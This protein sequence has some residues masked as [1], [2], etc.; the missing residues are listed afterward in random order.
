S[1]T[2]SP[3]LVVAP[4]SGGGQTREVQVSILCN[5][6]S[7]I[8][9]GLQIQAPAGWTVQPARTQF[10]LSRK[11]ESYAAR[12]VLH[13]P[14]GTREGIYPLEAAA[15]TGTKEFR[16]GYRIVSYPENWT[17]HLYSPSIAE[18]KTFDLEV[19]PSLTVG[20]VPGAG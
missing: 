15:S 20:Y 18:V 14:P 7:G 3:E 4:T 11:G 5:E 1:V 10:A 9:G 12:F 19:A 17:R 16:R 6:K 8:G 2:L 13:I